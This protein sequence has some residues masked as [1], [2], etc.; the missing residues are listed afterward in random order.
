MTTEAGLL[1]ALGSLSYATAAT[2]AGRVSYYFSNRVYLLVG[3]HIAMAAGLGIVFIAWRLAVALLGVTIM[4]IGFGLSL[5]L[6]RSMITE[7]APSSSRGGL[8]SLA[9]SGGRFTST[10]TPIMMGTAIAVLT[11]WLGF[12]ASVRVVGVSIGLLAS[13]I[14]VIALLLASLSMPIQHA[15]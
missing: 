3:M 9:E 11:S 13:T 14:G 2:Q 12:A 4:G 6:Y 8:V 10:V 1:A 15:G 5:S 7:L